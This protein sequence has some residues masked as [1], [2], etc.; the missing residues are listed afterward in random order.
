MTGCD[1]WLEV[2]S[3]LKEQG[4]AI[5]LLW[6][7]DDTHLEKAR[8]LFGKAVISMDKTRAYPFTLD[9]VGYEGQFAGFWKSENYLRAKDRCLK[10]LDRL[11]LY[12]SF[13]RKDKEIYFQNLV[14]WG[15]K[16]LDRN[17]PDALIMSESPHSHNQYILYEICLYAGIPM[18]RFNHFYFGPLIYLIRYD[19]GELISKNLLNN[20]CGEI[21]LDYIEK[22]CNNLTEV[23]KSKEPNYLPKYLVNQTENIKIGKLFKRVTKFIIPSL[24]REIKYDIKRF[25]RYGILKNNYDP[26][27]P[28]EF[29]FIQRILINNKLRI[30]L[31]KEINSLKNINSFSQDYVYFPLSFEPERTTNPDGGYF[32]DQLLAIVQ[33]RK[34]FPKDIKIVVKEHPT[35]L[36]LPARSYLGR[37]PL[38]YK[39]LS[40]IENL[41][42]VGIGSNTLEL[43]KNSRAVS[44]ITGSVAIESALLEKRVIV[45]GETWYDGAPNIFNWSEDLN[46]NILMSQKIRTSNEVSQFLVNKAKS[47]CVPGTPVPS[48][49]NYHK[50]KIE[51]IP[52]YHEESISSIINL[53]QEAFNSV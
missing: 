2:A 33:I 14:L 3:I 27:N 19:T 51:S 15:L 35:Q 45:F 12:G 18:F 42:V 48:F 28:F 16:Y 20:K 39:T 43:I 38:F 13:G 10:M 5:P 29:N 6:L 44:T 52:G 4:I 53:L 1:H 26:I 7:G 37:S 50:D 21:L 49:E 25:I 11:D 36:L 17:F 46:F 22:Y 23:A 34:I 40:N 32:H 41:E 9:E 24:L 31:A 30:N 8:K 47:I